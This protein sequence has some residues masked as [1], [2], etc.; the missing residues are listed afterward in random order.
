MRAA[1]Y[2]TVGE[3]EDVLQVGTLPMPTLGAGEVLVRVHAS[4]VNPSNTK[5]RVGWLG[6]G[7][8]APRLRKYRPFQQAR[9][10]VYTLKLAST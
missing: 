2:N 9:K 6:T 7:T 5:K 4:S 10:F 1:W 3:A 8:I